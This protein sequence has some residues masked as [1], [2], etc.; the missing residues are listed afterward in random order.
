MSAPV[1]LKPVQLKPVQLKIVLVDSEPEVWRQVVVPAEVTL[2]DLHE[3]IQRAMGWERLHDY[4]FQ[5]GLGADRRAV[6]NEKLLADALQMA[7]DLPFYYNYDSES[8]WRHRLV[9]EPLAEDR[10]NRLPV[11][12]AGAAACP[13]EGT[14]GVWG[15]DRLLVRLE[16]MEDPDYVEL[17]DRYGDFDPDAFD[18]SSINARLLAT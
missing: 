12:V 14:G 6:S 4:S 10:P 15:Y 2:T 9:A 11:C 18:L 13:P 17:L 7:G 3:I 5:V 16:D 8:G 1:Q